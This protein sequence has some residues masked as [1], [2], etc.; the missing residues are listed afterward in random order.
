MIEYNTHLL[1]VTTPPSEIAYN[2]VIVDAYN[3]TVSK[4]LTIT[5]STYTKARLENVLKELKTELILINEDFKVQF[6]KDMAMLIPF[7]ANATELELNESLLYAGVNNKL[8]SLNKTAIKEIIDIGTMTFF[9]VDTNGTVHTSKIT[10]DKMLK[11]IAS[12]SYAKVRSVM[13]AEYAIGTSVECIATKIKPFMID[14]PRSQIRNAVRTM[15]GEASQR[16][17]NEF[18]DANSEYIEEYLFVATID[19]RTSNICRSMDAMRF[20]KKESWNTPPIHNSCRSSLIALP[21]G[22]TA[23]QRPVVQQ[24]GTITIVNDKNFSYKDAIKMFP[25]L[26]NKELIDMI[27][28]QKQI[29]Y[30]KD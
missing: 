22:Y 24:D 15:F 28:Y 5:E 3:S 25:D 9:R 11:Y 16:A 1:S 4:L 10:A 14:T 18:Y 26:N 6:E 17:K 7:D 27:E 21:K 8:Y 23:T 20:K 2:K 13:L 12:D 30:Y 19:S 29:Q